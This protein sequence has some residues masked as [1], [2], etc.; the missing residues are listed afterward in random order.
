MANRKL[1]TYTFSTRKSAERMER[2]LE[3]KGCEIVCLDLA[4]DDVTWFLSYYDE[5]IDD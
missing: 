3:S 1:K 5:K 2:Y 4:D